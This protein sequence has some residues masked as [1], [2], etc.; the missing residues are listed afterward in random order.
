M[1]LI[2]NICYLSDLELCEDAHFTYCIPGAE[3][4]GQDQTYICVVDG[5]GGWRSR[6]V[7]PRL[8]AQRLCDNAKAAI[9][10]NAEVEFVCL[11]V[12]ASMYVH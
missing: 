5:V 6:G 9:E 1:S 4:G 3:G 12:Y 11:R 8:F 10:L 7:D 2:I